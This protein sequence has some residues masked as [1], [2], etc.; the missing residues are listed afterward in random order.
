MGA[1][2]RL[3]A[4]FLISTHHMHPLRVQLGRAM[5]QLTNGLDA[6]VELLRILGALVIEPIAG[7]MGFE[8]RF[9]L[10]NARYCEAKCC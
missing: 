7:L 5:I 10:K 4:G 3:H 1:L 6:F 9:V 8:L 2:I